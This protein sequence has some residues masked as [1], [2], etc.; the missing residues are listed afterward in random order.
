MGLKLAGGT[1]GTESDLLSHFDL[2][3]RPQ[4]KGRNWGNRTRFKLGFLRRPD[5]LFHPDPSSPPA[6]AE[7]FD[8]TGRESTANG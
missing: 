6:R 8:Q 1:L 7:P 3:A 2:E 4:L 5:L